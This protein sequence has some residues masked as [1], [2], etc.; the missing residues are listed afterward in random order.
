M[1]TRV[2]AH[3]FRCFENFEF[4]I[5]SLSSALLV[6]KNGSGKS[7]LYAVLKIFQAIGRGRS[8]IGDLVKRSDFTLG[9]TDIP[10]RFQIEVTLESRNFS[11]EIALELPERFQQLRILQEQVTMDGEKLFSRERGQVS[12][13]RTIQGRPDETQFTM[14]WY[15]AALPVIQNPAA[16]NAL[17]MLREWLSSMVLLAPIPKLMGG[18]A[19]TG[20]LEPNE[21]A[22]NWSDWLSGLLDR[23]PSAYSTVSNYLGQVMPDLADFR[24]ERVGKETKSLLVR[25]RSER[26]QFELPV[27][28]LSDG[29]KCFFLCAVVLAANDVDGPLFTFWDEPD[30]HLSINEVSHFVTALRRGVGTEGQIIMTSHSMEAIRRFSNENTWVM[31]RRSHMEPTL[32]RQLGEMSLAADLTSL[33][34]DGDLNPWQ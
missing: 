14:D 27:E 9:R 7:T 33:M 8:R 3:N 24:F 5:G 15:L 34:I 2:Y 17:G 10:I 13:F 30:S 28:A 29:E 21:S 22:D 4:K 25:F 18:E 19:G 26:D 20:T 32:I 6:G 23:Y 16:A 11:Y 31:G 1:L 12:L